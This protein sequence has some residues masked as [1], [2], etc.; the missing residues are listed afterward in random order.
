MLILLVMSE[1]IKS[2][3]D[4]FVNGNIDLTLIC[5]GHT[6]FTIFIEVLV[7]SCPVNKW[8]NK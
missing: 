2:I 5:L 8:L 7:N 4:Y 6:L 3:I 1:T